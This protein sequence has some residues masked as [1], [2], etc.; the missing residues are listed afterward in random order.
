MVICPTPLHP[1]DTRPNHS[2]VL[3]HPHQRDKDM[4]KLASWKCKLMQLLWQPA[5][6]FLQVACYCCFTALRIKPRA[7]A[8]Q[9]SILQLTH[10]TG[11]S[12]KF[13]HA[14]TWWLNNSVCLYVYVC[15]YMYAN[16][17]EVETHVRRQKKPCAERLLAAVFTTAEMWKQFQCWQL[18]NEQTQ[19]GL[20]FIVCELYFNKTRIF[21]KQSLWR[22]FSRVMMLSFTAWSTRQ[23]GAPRGLDSGFQCTSVARHCAGHAH[24]D[25]EPAR[26]MRKALTP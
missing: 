4:E 9:N 3:V 18:M 15:V 6:H 14:V 5:W 24:W 23:E 13:K 7:C 8:F 26:S 11:P 1:A 20:N 25:L 16:P 19:C 10:T 12:Q 2:M 22:S 21:F 17:R